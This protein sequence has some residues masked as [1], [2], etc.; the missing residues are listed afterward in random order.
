MRLRATKPESARRSR[1]ALGALKREGRQAATRDALAR[2]A[3]SSAR[4][5]GKAD[6]RRA[7]RRA[8]V[9]RARH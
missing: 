3:R 4:R 6:L 8:A 2:Q 1:A 9:T 5:R 7:A